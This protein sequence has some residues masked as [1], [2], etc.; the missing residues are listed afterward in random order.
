MALAAY[1]VYERRVRRSLESRQGDATI[2]EQEHRQRADEEPSGSKRASVT[3]LLG[4]ILLV[5]AVLFWVAAPAILLTPLSAAQ[6]A[7]TSSAF[8]VL[9][10]VAFWVAALAL[11]REVF[12]RYR[13]FL[14]PRDWFGKE[15][16]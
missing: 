10:E 15:R 3:R 6:K 8:L 16:R 4:I 13:R 9:G 7:W 14:D 5:A 1:L 11:G 12:R 2:N